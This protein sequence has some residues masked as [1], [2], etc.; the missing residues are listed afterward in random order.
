MLDILTTFDGV[1]P[2]EAKSIHRE[3]RGIVVARGEVT[4]HAHVIPTKGIEVMELNGLRIVVAPTEWT[5]IHEEHKALTFP[6]G[7]YEIVQE[8]EWS[9]EDEPRSVLD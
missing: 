4:G 3:K 2:A 8:R 6:A 1:V 7:L 5:V 9:D